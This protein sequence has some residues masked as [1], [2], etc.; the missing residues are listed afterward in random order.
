MSGLKVANSRG[1]GALLVLV[2]WLIEGDIPLTAPEVNLPIPAVALIEVSMRAPA[3]IWQCRP[4]SSV[5]GD[6]TRHSV[7]H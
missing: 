4:T 6:F 5:E 2:R 7:G 3:K 1:G